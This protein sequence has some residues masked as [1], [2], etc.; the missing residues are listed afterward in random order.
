MASSLSS[1]SI[2]VAEELIR[3]KSD[4]NSSICC[5]IDTDLKEELNIDEHDF[6]DLRQQLDMLHNSCDEG[7]QETERTVC[8]LSGRKRGGKF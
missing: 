5:K 7:Y 3:A 8:K 4:A 6:R 2:P 1:P